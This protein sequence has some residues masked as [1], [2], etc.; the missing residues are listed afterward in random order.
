MLGIIGAMEVE[1]SGIVEAMECIENVDAGGYRFVVGLLCGKRIVVSRCGIGKVFSSTAAALMID[2]FGVSEI[3]NIGVAGGAKPLRQG[4]VVIGERCVQHDYDA[5][6]DGCELGQVHGFTSPYFMCDIGIVNRLETVMRSLG[7]TY[8]KGTIASG[9]CFVS[10]AKKSAN[11]SKCFGAIVY[12]MESAAIAQVCAFQG[13]AFCSMR[14]IS[15]NGDDDAIDSFYDFVS[16]AA[17][18]SIDVITA[19]V[20]KFA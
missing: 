3:I 8:S 6:A 12:D 7:Y 5:T 9:D 17:A 2:K 16:K 11:I 1:T 18:R 19:Y 4:D 14:A 13:V 20:R 15:D 10:D